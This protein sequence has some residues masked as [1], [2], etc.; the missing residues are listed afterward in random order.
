MALESGPDENLVDF[1]SDAL[2]RMLFL[3]RS[4]MES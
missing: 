2:P 4:K 3:G 1:F